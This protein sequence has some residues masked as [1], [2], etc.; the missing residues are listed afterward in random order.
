MIT[1]LL[2]HWAG[3]AHVLGP[4]VTTATGRTSLALGVEKDFRADG[5]AQADVLP[6]P[7]LCHGSRLLR[8]LGHSVLLN[9]G[10]YNVLG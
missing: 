5:A 9:K 8:G 4:F 1:A 3:Q 7:E 6:F 10:V 2:E